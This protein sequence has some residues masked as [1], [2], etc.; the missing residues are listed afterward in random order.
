MTVTLEVI[1]TDLEALKKE[2][3][4]LKRVIVPE[5]EMSEEERKEIRKTLAEMEK[6]DETKLEDVLKD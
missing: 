1:H 3:E 5:E 6:G 2:V 4:N